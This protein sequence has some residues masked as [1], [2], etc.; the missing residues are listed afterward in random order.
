MVKNPLIRRRSPHFWG[1]PPAK[2]NPPRMSAPVGRDRR[3]ARGGE[4]GH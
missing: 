1:V 4:E 2:S 3:P